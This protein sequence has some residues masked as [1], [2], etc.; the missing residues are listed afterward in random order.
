MQPMRPITAADS[1]LVI[2]PH[3]DDESLCCAGVIDLAERAG[4][5][6]AIAWV[7][8]GDGSVSNAM[9]V[10]RTLL[11]GK[12]GY[13]ELGRRREG[14][15]REAASS[16]G[17]TPDRQ[18]FL[19]YPDR[20]ILPLILTH[21]ESPWRSPRTGAAAVILERAVTP[22]SAYEGRLLERDLAWIVDRV[23]PTIV[24][25][26]SPR[27]AHP[28]HRGAGLMS[29]R[30]MSE[31]GGLDRVHYWI[32]HGGHAWPAPRALRPEL[33]QT[34]PPRGRGMDWEFVALDEQALAAKRRALEAHLSPRR[35]MGRVMDSHVRATEL[36]ARTPGAPQEIFCLQGACFAEH[37]RQLSGNTLALAR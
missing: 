5:K 31:R 33:P 6:V 20:G 15:A 21:Y 24:L 17:V 28:D 36:F 13:R 14:E 19:G 34:I 29:M 9:I 4:A 2:A 7:T 30:V 18:F 35:A 27:D 22:G 3:P 11:P 37:D 12:R 16:L 26:P 10:G 25:A 23:D 32:V 1:L 8:D